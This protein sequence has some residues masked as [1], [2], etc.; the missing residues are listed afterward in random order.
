MNIQSNRPHNVIFQTTPIGV[1]FLKGHTGL[2]DI[3]SQQ[4]GVDINFKDDKGMTLVAIAAASPLIGG[5]Y[6]QVEY[7]VKQKKADATITDSE[8]SDPVS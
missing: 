2:A 7:L 8:G 4:P 3:L 1:A 6:Q 5:L